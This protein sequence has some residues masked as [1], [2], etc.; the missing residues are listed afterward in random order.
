M[1][2]FYCSVLFFLC[3]FVRINVFIVLA[4]QVRSFIHFCHDISECFLVLN[5]PKISVYILLR[6]R[7]SLFVDDIFRRAQLANCLI[8]S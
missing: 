5:K 3:C 1:L 4:A 8:Y 2:L 7:Q 6:K